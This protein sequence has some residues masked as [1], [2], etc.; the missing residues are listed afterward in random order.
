[1]AKLKT[2]EEFAIEK[3]QTVEHKGTKHKEEEVEEGNAFGDAVRKAKEAGDSEFEF[4]GETFKV[5]EQEEV[6]ESDN[7]KEGVTKVN[8]SGYVKAG[9]LGYNDQFLGKRSLSYTISSE[10]GLD[11][12]N[13]FGSGDWIGFDG[14]TMY[15]SGKKE[16]TIS[17]DA[18]SDKYTYAEL[19]DMAAKHLGLKESVLNEAS[20]QAMKELADLA[21]LLNDEIKANYI[22]I[23]A[24]IDAMDGKKKFAL[25]K[26]I[27]TLLDQ[28]T[29]LTNAGFQINKDK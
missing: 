27:L 3:Q 20:G 13:E 26:R 19:K 15:A 29:K 23:K 24:G 11:S 4:E 8:P 16:G 2:F 6:D 1:M 18:L 25:E 21:V 14:Q 10:L 12:K 17:K 22:D 5:E 7:I 28:L 9:I